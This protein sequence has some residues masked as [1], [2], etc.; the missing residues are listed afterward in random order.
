MTSSGSTFAC[1]CAQVQDA[2]PAVRVRAAK[3]LAQSAAR[4]ADVE[5]AVTESVIALT[6]P[7]KKNE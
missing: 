5:A 1:E 7:I 3:A 2:S 6:V 4:G